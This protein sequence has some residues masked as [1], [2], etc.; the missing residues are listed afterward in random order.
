M[1]K[2][3]TPGKPIVHTP[4]LHQIATS[5]TSMDNTNTPGTASYNIT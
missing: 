1:D 3:N 5:R 2:T 4:Q